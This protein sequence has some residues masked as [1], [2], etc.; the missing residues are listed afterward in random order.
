M[1]AGKFGLRQDLLGQIPAGPGAP[2]AQRFVRLHHARGEVL[3][4]TAWIADELLGRPLLQQPYR[5]LIRQWPFGQDRLCD[6]QREGKRAIDEQQALGRESAHP[7]T[8]RVTQCRV[9]ERATTIIAT[10]FLHVGKTVF[11]VDQWQ[12]GIGLVHGSSLL[13]RAA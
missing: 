2:G 13:G 12:K 10:E 9:V 11:T 6:R 4:V 3:P 7:Q 1:I 5:R 8:L